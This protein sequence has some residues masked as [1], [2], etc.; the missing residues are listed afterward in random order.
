MAPG[1]GRLDDAGVHQRGAARRDVPLR[2]AHVAH[3]MG[4]SFYI[5]GEYVELE[6]YHRIVHVE[7]MFLPDRTPGNRAETTFDPDGP[8]T[9]MTV[10]YD[11]ARCQD[12]RQHAADRR[13]ARNGSQL[14]PSRIDGRNDSGVNGELGDWWRRG[15]SNARPRD[16]E[17]LA[18]AS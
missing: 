8:G 16:Y 3:P 14:C 6:P 7:R 5:T 1:S 17:T 13:G 11:L 9:L 15:D 12:A 18:L 10:R 2:V 4:G